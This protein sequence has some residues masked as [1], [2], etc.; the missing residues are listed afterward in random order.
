[1]KEFKIRASAAGQI[2]TGTIGLTE[3]Q[4]KEFIKLSEKEKLTDIQ[5]A[6]L[7]ELT[8]KREHPELPQTLKSYCED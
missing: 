4:N 1:M 5:N 2:M 8:N 6:R 3:T 7:M